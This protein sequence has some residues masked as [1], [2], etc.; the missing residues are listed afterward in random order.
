[1]AAKGREGLHGASCATGICR[2]VRSRPALARRPACPWWSLIR[3]GRGRPCPDFL[4]YWSHNYL[5]HAGPHAPYSRIQC[6]NN[7]L[8]GVLH[9]LGETARGDRGRTLGARGRAAGRTPDNVATMQIH[10]LPRLPGLGYPAKDLPWKAGGRRAFSIFDRLLRSAD[11]L[12][13]TGRRLGDD[14]SR[15]SLA[16]DNSRRTRE[17]PRTIPVNEPHGAGDVVC[18]RDGGCHDPHRGA[19]SASA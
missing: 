11:T 16:P 9:V 10:C 19:A 4:A 1:V 14:A 7:A 18:L 3:C 17:R 13:R 5:D 12:C 6:K 8:R 15:P 2:S